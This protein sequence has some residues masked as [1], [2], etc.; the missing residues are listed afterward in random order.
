MCIIANSVHSLYQLAETN[1]TQQ[2][3]CTFNHVYLQKVNPYKAHA[4]TVQRYM[5]YPA[6]FVS[7]ALQL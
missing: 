7:F 4:P 2:N 5:R 6:R 3:L 1:I